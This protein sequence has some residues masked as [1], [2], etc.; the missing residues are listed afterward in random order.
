MVDTPEF[1]PLQRDFGQNAPWWVAV[2]VLLAAGSLGECCC[3][4]PA[5]I[6]VEAD[7]PATPESVKPGIN[8]R[9]LDPDLNPD[10][11]VKRFEVESREV[12]RAR[13]AV[14]AACGL[15]PGDT[16][17]DVGAGTGLFTMIFAK[18]VGPTGTVYAVD[19]AEKFV[20]RIDRIAEQQGLSQVEPL[21]VGDQDRRMP[22]AGVDCLFVCDVYHHF[23]Y[24]QVTDVAL[25]RSLKPGGRLILVDFERI[26]GQSSDF[27][28]G[29]VRAGREVFRQELEAAGFEFVGQKSI[30]GLSEN[31]CLEFRRPQD[32]E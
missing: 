9:Y 6:A 14:A 24:P 4:Q 23:E 12:F 17:G 15:Q 7:A 3:A 2:L 31:Y 18:Q 10:E 29:H 27:V 25:L 26:E 16:I 21:V 32:G 19:I 11:W 13:H 8:D 22:F 1:C 5:A 20:E 28:M 30:D